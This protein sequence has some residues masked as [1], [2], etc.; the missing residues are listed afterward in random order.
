MCGEVDIPF[1]I[2]F[3]KKFN[4]LGLMKRAGW[5]LNIVNDPLNMDIIKIQDG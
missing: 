2:F 4:P 3:F 1:L 5:L